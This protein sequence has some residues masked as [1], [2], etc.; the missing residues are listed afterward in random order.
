MAPFRSTSLVGLTLRLVMVAACVLPLLS[1]RQ[2]AAAFA[3][4]PVSAAPLGHLPA[5]PV[6]EEDEN[7]RGSS[8]ER[9]ADPRG[10]RRPDRPRLAED[11]FAIVYPARTP[12]ARA[13]LPPSRPTAEDP[14]RNG[15]G[16]HY[17]C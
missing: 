8:E 5:A 3:F 1:P 14:F 17:R 7:E 16:S 13:P 2:V 12:S 10:E 15:L 9:T 11:R 6:N 4:L